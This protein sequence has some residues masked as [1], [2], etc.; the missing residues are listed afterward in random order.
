MFQIHNGIGQFEFGNRQ[1]THL[2]DG[3]AKLNSWRFDGSPTTAYFSTEFLGTGWYNDSVKTNNVAPYMTFSKPNPPFNAMG[4][5]VALMH[6]QDNT[7]VNVLNYNGDYVAVG[8]MWRV[9]T[10]DPVKLTT[11]ARVNPPLPENIHPLMENSMSSSH[12]M[13]EYG[14]S[15]WINF[16]TNMD[17]EGKNSINVMRIKSADERETIAQIMTPHVHYM[18]SFAATEK[19]AIFFANPMYMNMEK[20][21]TNMEPRT[22][23]EYIPED[24]TKV[25]V[26]DIKS[27]EVIEME[28]IPSV[29]LHH[30]NAYHLDNNT[31]V[32]DLIEYSSLATIQGFMFESI[33]NKTL[34]DSIPFNDA[35]IMRYVINLADKTVMPM[36]FHTLPGHEFINHFD[37]PVINEEYRYKPYCYTYGVGM[38]SD[39]EVMGDFRLVK[40]DVCDVKGDGDTFWHQDNHYPSE[41]WFVPL[42]DAKLED[43]GYLLSIIL[44]GEKEQ[45]YLAI[46][47]AK[48]LTM[49]NYSYLTFPIPFPL[50]GR[51]F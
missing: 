16:Y 51:Y 11:T 27:G 32:I 30:I 20:M 18:H 15:N 42:P 14:T 48:T 41:P 10:I 36:P 2:F 37:F 29:V 34:R 47:D 22:A 40:K 9:Y 5:I 19:Y 39:G 35:T 44:D 46:F 6:G 50:H 33:H 8:D 24:P 13:P 21:M 43:D 7:C 49:I 23:M 38:R 26:V 25:F 1:V 45:S 17:L 31:I 12:P 3:Y 4:Q 28:T